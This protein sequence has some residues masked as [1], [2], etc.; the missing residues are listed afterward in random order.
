LYINV[1]LFT[2]KHAAA[3]DLPLTTQLLS[4]S[5]FNM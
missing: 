1:V 3:P 4:L 5:A 2:P